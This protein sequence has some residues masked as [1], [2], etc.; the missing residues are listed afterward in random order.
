MKYV[1]AR[2]VF[3]IFLSMCVIFAAPSITQ[4]GVT[5]MSM[6]YVVLF[7]ESIC[8]PTIV[9]LGMRGLGRHTKRGSG[10]LVAGVFGGAIVPPLTGAAA[11]AHGTPLAMVVP[12]MFFVA[13]LSY[14][15][16]VNFVPAYR[17]TA[18]AFT[19]AE[20]GLHGHPDDVENGD[21]G[22]AGDRVLSEKG[23]EAEH[24]K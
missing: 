16:A 19:T 24:V 21:G 5:G 13:A 22:D 23:A 14:A 6:L 10:W 9:A 8:F 12:L 3:L 11:D 18:D 15:I 2:W 7:F 20:I 17:D 1:R 4:R